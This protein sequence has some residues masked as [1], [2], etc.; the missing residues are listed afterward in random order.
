[1]EAAQQASRLAALKH[2]PEPRSQVSLE[3]A[4]RRAVDGVKEEMVPVGVGLD[5]PANILEALDSEIRPH[6]LR[7]HEALSERA[8][9]RATFVVLVLKSRLA[10]RPYAANLED[11]V[12][13]SRAA[14]SVGRSQR[15]DIYRTLTRRQGD[16]PMRRR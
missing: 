16:R 5:P 13:S 2:R 15:K 12:F 9:S 11:S 10:V 4:K 8:A 7:L 1:T 3:V 6:D 14:S